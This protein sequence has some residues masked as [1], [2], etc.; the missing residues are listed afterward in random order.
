MTIE[1]ADIGLFLTGGSANTNPNASLGGNVSTTQVVSNNLHNLFR[2]ITDSEASSG[3]TLYRC[4]ALKNRDAVDELRNLHFYMVYDT[5]SADSLALYSRAQAGRNVVETAVANE[6]T[7]PTG[8]NINFI[9]ALNRS[10]GLSLGNLGVGDFINIWLRYTVQPGSI[11]FA[12]DEFKI[13]AEV[14][15]SSTTNPPTPA[16]NPDTGVNFQMAALGDC[17]CSSNFSNMW[18]RIKNRGPEFVIFNGDLAYDDG[19]GCWLSLTSGWRSKSVISF[20]NHDVDES[21]DQPET[22]NALI[23]AYSFL[24]GKTYGKKTFNN[25]GIVI[26]ESGENQSVSDSVGSSQYNFVKSAL[27]GFKNN[28]AIEWIFVCNHYPI[29]GPESDHDNESGTRDRYDPLFDAND[30]DVVFTSHNHNL[31]HTRLLKYDSGSPSSPLEAGTDPNYSYRKSAD[32]HGKL[33]IGTGAGGRSH[34]DIESTPGYV[35]YSN[36][37]DYGYV[38]MEFSETGKKITFKIY[39]SSDSL[40]KTFTLTHT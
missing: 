29:Y 40:K 21:E 10:G 27:E 16:P 37:N 4:L 20:G 28:D 15:T 34:Y 5:K 23:N 13:R 22:K 14:G 12:N 9:A 25:V 32:N 26:M 36:D 39:S 24:N 38:W 11:N 2:R 33:Y 6:F 35:Q 18:N 1:P 3:V 7:A 8:S 19:S 31:W 30:V 17:S